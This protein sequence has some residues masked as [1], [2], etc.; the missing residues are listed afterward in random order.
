MRSDDELYAAFLSGDETACDELMIRHGDNLVFYLNGCVHNPEDAEDLMIEAFARIMVKKPRI[1]EGAFKAY[2]YKT[3]RRLAARLHEKRRSDV[4]SLDEL[5][6][7]GAEPVSDSDI[8]KNDERR[9][10]L[11]ACLRRI[12][13]ELREALWLFYYEGMSYEEAAGI[14]RV[15]KK[16]IDHLLARGRECL[17]AELAKEGVTDAYD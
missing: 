8:Y 12:P 9:Q 13:P 1:G 17:K 6:S 4:F 11:N 16:R 15:N 7:G 10:I 14:M 5:S 3:A 2:L